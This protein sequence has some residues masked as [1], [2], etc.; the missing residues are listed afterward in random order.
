LEC[1]IEQHNNKLP[2]TETVKERKET[3]SQH[4][5]ILNKVKDYIY[6]LH[7]KKNQVK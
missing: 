4:V 7:E 6:E 5:V 1:R 2:N 3:I